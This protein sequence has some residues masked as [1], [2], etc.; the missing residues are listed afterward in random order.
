MAV[1]RQSSLH[2]QWSHLLSSDPQPIV[3]AL[4]RSMIEVHSNFSEAPHLLKELHTSPENRLQQKSNCIPKNNLMAQTIRK[5]VF[6]N[7]I[8]IPTILG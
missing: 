7:S 1:D 3:R 2:G 5:I 8:S 6:R 4:R